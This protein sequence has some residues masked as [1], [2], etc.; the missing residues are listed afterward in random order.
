MSTV[1]VYN[2]THF[3]VKVMHR[4]LWCKMSNLAVLAHFFLCLSIKSCSVLLVRQSLTILNPV[5][6]FNSP[7]LLLGEFKACN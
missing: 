4:G 6:L 5:Y 2:I 1:G 7:V 3:S